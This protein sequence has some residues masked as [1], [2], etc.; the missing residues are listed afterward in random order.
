MISESKRRMKGRD[1]DDDED[2]ETSYNEKRGQI[3]TRQ[4]Y[5]H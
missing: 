4:T 5:A 1:D 2:E 3:R